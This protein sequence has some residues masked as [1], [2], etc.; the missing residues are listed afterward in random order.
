MLVSTIK[1]NPVNNFNYVS[2]V[3]HV[4]SLSHTRIFHTNMGDIILS[5][6]TVYCGVMYI[7]FDSIQVQA[8]RE[9]FS[10]KQD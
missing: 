1:L 2:L 10:K 4:F 8:Q 7:A 5:V 9:A 6:L 3:A